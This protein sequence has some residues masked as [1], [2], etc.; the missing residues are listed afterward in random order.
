MEAEGRRWKGPTALLRLRV[1][2]VP[3]SCIFKHAG[4]TLSIMWMMA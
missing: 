4:L 2:E 1:E 3:S